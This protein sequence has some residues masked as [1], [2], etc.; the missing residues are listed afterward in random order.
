MENASSCPYLEAIGARWE[1]HSLTEGT[2]KNLAPITTINSI[3]VV[4]SNHHVKRPGHYCRGNKAP[5]ALQ[6]EHVTGV[7][8]CDRLVVWPA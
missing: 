4:R 2:F 5:T 7:P 3:A 8:S 1:A 6:V